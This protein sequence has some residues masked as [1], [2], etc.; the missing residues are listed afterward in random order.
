MELTIL[1]KDK[2]TGQ[3]CVFFTKW[4]LPTAT[5]LITNM[6]YNV[7]EVISSSEVESVEPVPEK[8]KR[9]LFF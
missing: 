8:K 3:P 4:A 9:F 2:V 5:E 7:E 1:T 6:G